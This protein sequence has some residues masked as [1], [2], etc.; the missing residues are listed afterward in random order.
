MNSQTC[1]STGNKQYCKAT[2][3]PDDTTLKADDFSHQ[4]FSPHPNIYR[5]ASFN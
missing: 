1:F 4:E 2:A 3:E 5:K